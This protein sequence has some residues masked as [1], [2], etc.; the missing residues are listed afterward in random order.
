MYTPG[1]SAPVNSS[2]N[3]CLKKYKDASETTAVCML[4][5][6]YLTFQE[7]LKNIIIDDN[8]WGRYI[9]TAN[10]IKRLALEYKKDEK[11]HDILADK[12]LSDTELFNKCIVTTAELIIVSDVFPRHKEKLIE[13]IKTHSILQRVVRTERDRSSLSE[14]FPELVEE[15]LS[16]SFSKRLQF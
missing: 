12:F 13:K 6:V 9:H 8:G 10:D 11:K 4:F 7:E 14:K 16:L 3:D 15:M 2:L 1:F 5:E